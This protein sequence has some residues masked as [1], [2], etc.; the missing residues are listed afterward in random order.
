MQH[1]R[2]ACIV[3]VLALGCG[4]DGGS[5]S[6]DAPGPDTPARACD[7]RAYDPC[8][9]TTNSTDCMANLQC[10]FFMGQNFTIC[11]PSCDA[12]T[13]CPVDDGGNDVAC[14]NMGRC[15]PAAPNTCTR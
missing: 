4:D 11:T 10:R 1:L 6:I 7:G 9:D 5:K 15:R 12:S 14:N 3:V 8:T 13:P 2:L